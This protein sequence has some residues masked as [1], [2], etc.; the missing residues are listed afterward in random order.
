MASSKKKTLQIISDYNQ[1]LLK[2]RFKVNEKH[3]FSRE[4]MRY[5]GSCTYDYVDSFIEENFQSNALYWFIY[6]LINY[7]FMDSPFYYMLQQLRFG[8]SKITPQGISSK[9][10]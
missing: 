6:L 9:V 8:T 2:K 10:R 7:L 4:K 1:F 5:S 3:I